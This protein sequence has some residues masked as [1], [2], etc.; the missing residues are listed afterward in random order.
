NISEISAAIQQQGGAS[1]SI[2]VQVEHTAQMS[3]QSSAAAKQTA[4]SA[5]YLDQLV[6]RQMNTLAQFQV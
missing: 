1:N 4:E 3:E 5:S 2:A 6:K